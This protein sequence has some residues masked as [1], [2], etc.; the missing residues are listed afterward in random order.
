MEPESSGSSG[1]VD[2][3]ILGLDVGIASVGAAVL[4]LGQEMIE[5]LYVRAF[6]KAEV[7]KTG[8]SLNAV[9]REARG[10]RRRLR[11]RRLRLTD[12]LTTLVESSQGDL[13]SELSP[14]ELPSAAWEIRAR[15]LDSQRPGSNPRDG[16]VSGSGSPGG[17]GPARRRFVPWPRQDV[18]RS[19]RS[20]LSSYR[21]RR[22]RMRSG[23]WS[24]TTTW[25]RSVK[26]SRFVRPSRRSRQSLLNLGSTTT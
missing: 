2:F 8:E 6:D 13:P 17:S 7:A 18:A 4:N 11:R 5:G 9:R 1:P 10:V 20:R 23:G 26:P 14:A 15:G 19:R 16:S 24:G 12:T 22:P 25:T 3:R 21:R